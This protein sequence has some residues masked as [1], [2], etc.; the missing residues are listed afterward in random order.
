MNRSRYSK[1][2]TLSFLAILPFLAGCPGEKHKPSEP[3][4]PVE[5]SEHIRPVEPS[6]PIKPVEPREPIKPVLSS[7]PK[8]TED[9]KRKAEEEGEV[10]RNNKDALD[11]ANNLLIEFNGNNGTSKTNSPN[12]AQQKN[13]QTFFVNTPDF[14]LPPSS[15]PYPGG[16]DYNPGL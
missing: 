8:E 7:E 15:S 9:R 4:K 16:S 11:G 14:R 3:I 13:N 2:L 10:E 6:E 12:D 5:P 1:I